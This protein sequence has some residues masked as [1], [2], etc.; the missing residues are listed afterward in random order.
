M[1]F[2]STRTVA[3]RDAIP[4]GVLHLTEEKTSALNNVNKPASMRKRLVPP[5]GQQSPT[6]VAHTIALGKSLIHP[7]AARDWVLSGEKGGARLLQRVTDL[8]IELRSPGRL[9]VAPA[10][11]DGDSSS[12][13]RARPAALGRP[14]EPVWS[15]LSEGNRDNGTRIRKKLTSTAQ[16]PDSE[17]RLTAASGGSRMQQRLANTAE[18]PAASRSS[19]QRAE[20]SNQ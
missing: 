6:N 11:L 14:G 18:A 5:K 10:Q 13:L 2:K 7:Q 20:A 4:I 15:A 17:Q 12:Q 19:Q 16:A 1:R 3:V 8:E 9:R